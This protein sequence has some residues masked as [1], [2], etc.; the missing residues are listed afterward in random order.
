MK[1]DKIKF[2]V[3][4]FNISVNKPSFMVLSLDII[5]TG[6]NRHGTE[7]LIED[8]ERNIPKLNNIPLNCLFTASDMDFKA[9]AWTKQEL[10]DQV[11][12]GVIPETNNARIIEKEG[13]K[14]LR[15]NAIVWKYLF[16]QAEEILSRRKKVAISM[17]IDPTDG[18]QRENGGATVITEWEYEAITLLGYG[19][20]PAIPDANATV[21]KFSSNEE[22]FEQVMV[23]YGAIIDSY[24][25][26]TRIKNN[27]E[28]ELK[29]EQTNPNA[30]TQALNVFDKVTLNYSEIIA[31]KQ[32]VLSLDM[33]ARLLL[34]G[35]EF[36]KWTDAIEKERNGGTDNLDKLK[37]LL[38]EKFSDNLKYVSHNETDVFCFDYDNAQFKSFKYTYEEAKVEEEVEIEAKFAVEVEF[39]VVVK[40]EGSDAFKVEDSLEEGEVAEDAVMYSVKSY[41]KMKEE[42]EACKEKLSEEEG[43]VGELEA[44]KETYAT[45][46][47]KY[48]AD[49][50]VIK[51]EKTEL[52]NKVADAETKILEFAELSTEIEG[53]KKFKADKEKDEKQA[54][55]NKLYARYSELLTEDELKSLNEKVDVMEFSVFEK[56][57]KAIVLPKVEANYQMLKESQDLESKDKDNLKYNK[58]STEKTEL[59]ADKP[60][61]LVESL[62]ANY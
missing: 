14:F 39:E 52:E 19:V 37:E 3:D 13:V 54:E 47:E 17:E 49:L 1:F 10:A 56:E 12:I 8:I 29:K 23:K 32:T 20:T 48:E 41:S 35:Y 24:T 15:V 34:S 51:S 40:I 25:I 46:K 6:V 55:V 44:E 38:Q 43:K 42:L 9:H 7:F 53:L 59:D 21:V 61:N 18:Y 16:P 5:S 33:N 31:L 60:K 4:E 57:V 2:A 45:D 26:P 58:F 11:A 28:L 30:L 50:E 22:Y 36:L 27:I 62:R